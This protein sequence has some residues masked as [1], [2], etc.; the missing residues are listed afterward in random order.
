[1][2]NRLKLLDIVID[3]VEYIIGDVITDLKHHENTILF[4]SSITVAI[5]VVYQLREFYVEYAI[6]FG[7]IVLF[8]VH[9]VIAWVCIILITDKIKHF[10]KLKYLRL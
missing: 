10:L 1:M 6:Y 7:W 9:I 2:I 3:R 4:L 8:I 5:I